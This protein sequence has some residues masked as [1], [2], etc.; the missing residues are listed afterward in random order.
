[1]NAAEMR[2]TKAALGHNEFSRDQQISSTDISISQ[3]CIFTRESLWVYTETGNTRFNLSV[4]LVKKK[5]SELGTLKIY[6]IA[7]R[8]N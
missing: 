6:F 3:L 8:F 1:M 7:V 2:F 4:V 5:K